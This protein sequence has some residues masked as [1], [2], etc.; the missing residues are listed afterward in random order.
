MLWTLAVG[1]DGW[2]RW[3]IRAQNAVLLLL[4]LG[5]YLYGSGDHLGLLLSVVAVTYVAGLLLRSER[6][7]KTALVVG[8]SLQVAALA[9]FKYANFFVDQLG[10][11]SGLLGG[12]V[13][14][15]ASVALPVGISFFTFQA[16]SYLFD[17]YRREQQALRNPLDLALYI[18]MFPQLIAG[19]IV[20]YGEVAKQLHQRKLSGSLVATGVVRFAWGLF[21]KLVIADSV[22]VIA[23][24]AYGVPVDALTTPAAWLGAVAYALQIYFDFS[25]YSDMA[26]GL[27]GIFGFR[28]PENFR[29]PYSAD[30]ITDFWRRWHMTLSFWFRDYVY[31]PLG[32]SKSSRWS[33]YRNLWAVFLLSGLWHGADWTFVF[34]GAFH[35]ALLT[36]ERM[37]RG[38]KA[39]RMPV[40]LRRLRTFGLVVLGFAMFRADSMTQTLAI[41]K[42][43]FVPTDLSVPIEVALTLSHRNV[44]ILVLAL[45][46]TA[47]PGR[48]VAGRW[49]TEGKLDAALPRMARWTVLV[50]GTL[51]A[52]LTMAGSDFSPFIYFRF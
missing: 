4:S 18:S 37:W 50:G 28:F 6:W 24:A 29:R 7:S 48:F 20:R 26:I 22:A 10:A 44:G 23:D 19:P 46:S 52:S 33:T 36:F 3:G 27:G 2:R 35:G 13:V 8:V 5:F 16:I 17:I 1:V 43:I 30:S 14:E 25:A 12:P 40:A 41:W 47:L 31:I 32:G 9:Y 49:L 45:L 11:M 34:W 15:L 39:P 51:L 21:K 38:R 42:H